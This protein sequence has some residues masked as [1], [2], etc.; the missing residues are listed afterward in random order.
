LK[1]GYSF[2]RIHLPNS[3]LKLDIS[4]YADDSHL[5]K[6]L[7]QTLEEHGYTL[8]ASSRYSEEQRFRYHQL[9]ISLNV[10]GVSK[11]LEKEETIKSEV[12]RE[13]FNQKKK[14]KKNLIMN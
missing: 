6:S 4:H 10:N 13:L 14:Q 12:L 3:D 2:T 8:Q 1:W 11:E 9:A 5:V 7:K